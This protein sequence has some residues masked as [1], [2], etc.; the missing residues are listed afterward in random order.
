MFELSAKGRGTAVR[1]F[2]FVWLVGTAVPVVYTLGSIHPLTVAMDVSAD[3]LLILAPNLPF[4]ALAG[5]LLGPRI[6]SGGFLRSLGWQVIHAFLWACLATLWLFALLFRRELLQVFQGSL[7]I[8]SIHRLLSARFLEV[9]A[10]NCALLI[11]VTLLS[12]G[13]VRFLLRRQTRLVPFPS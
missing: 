2:S 4:A 5:F 7:S 8:G 3:L 10:V 13:I 9:L 11:P 1:T 6:R 12:S